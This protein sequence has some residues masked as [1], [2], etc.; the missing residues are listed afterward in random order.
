MQ[1][2][3]G[4]AALLAAL[5]LP[6]FYGATGFA[7][8]FADGTAWPNRVAPVLCAVL[9]LLSV[10]YVVHRRGG[11]WLVVLAAATFGATGGLWQRFEAPDVGPGVVAVFLA[12]ALLLDGL[13]DTLRERIDH[14]TLPSIGALVFTYQL[15]GPLRWLWLVAGAAALVG[16]AGSL[17]KRR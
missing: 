3:G 5:A 8:G 6:W 15:V 4:A 7:F 13:R 9:G 12:L 17:L 11:A 2:A 10:A 16:G 14:A 1:V